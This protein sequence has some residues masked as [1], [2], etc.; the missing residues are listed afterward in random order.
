MILLSACTTTN[1]QSTSNITHWDQH[2][3]LLQ[4]MDAWSLEGKLGYRHNKEGGSAWF[5]W[6]QKQHIFNVTLNGPFGV[7][8]TR[9]IGTNHH[10]QLFRA[11]HDTITA[12]SPAALTEALFGWQWPVEHLQFWIRGIPA[13]SV[14]PDIMNYYP[15]GT[16]A[17]LEQSQW[18]LQFFN[19]KKTDEWL[20]PMKIKGQKGDY[21][22]TLVIK[23]WQPTD[24]RNPNAAP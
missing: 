21:Q 17:Q 1:L 12:S 16:L 6:Q 24:K 14:T 15:E 5:N 4:K 20:L 13:P 19:Y 22:F 11:G 18:T 7:G 23:Q 10:A 3:A 2:V 8:A 9:I